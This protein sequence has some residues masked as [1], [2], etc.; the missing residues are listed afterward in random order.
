MWLE[1]LFDGKGHRNDQPIRSPGTPL[2]EVTE[3]AETAE[4]DIGLHIKTNHSFRCRSTNCAVGVVDRRRF[5]GI[6]GGSCGSC[7]ALWCCSSLW[8]DGRIASLIMLSSLWRL[9]E[10]DRRPVHVR[11]LAL[12]DP[13][14]LR[15]C[16]LGV[17]RDVSAGS[18][19]VAGCILAISPCA[20][21]SCPG[22]RRCA[23]QAPS[24]MTSDRTATI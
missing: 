11:R 21:K 8:L 15:G 13:P 23:G 24:R 18:V 16:G 14:G 4:M 12:V 1:D 20:N 22:R 19:F 2:F 3:A 6:P 17:D 10:L 9:V 5:G 7:G